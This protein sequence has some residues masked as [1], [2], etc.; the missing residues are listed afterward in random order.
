MASTL[1]GTGELVSK[2]DRP[3]EDLK[4][5]IGTQPLRIREQELRAVMEEELSKALQQIN[6]A[7]EK[8]TN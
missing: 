6:V 2:V 4:N 8:L 5:M 3:I 7:K 1:E